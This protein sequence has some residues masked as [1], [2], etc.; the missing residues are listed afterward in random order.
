[1]A[2]IVQED[3]PGQARS[4]PPSHPVDVAKVAAW[5][6]AVLAPWTVVILAARFII[7][8]LA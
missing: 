1:M 6:A 2:F 8:A 7:A 4:L 5:V 3:A